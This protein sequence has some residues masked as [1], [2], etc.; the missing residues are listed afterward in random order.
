[1]APS[2]G[3]A[4]ARSKASR[5]AC[6]PMPRL[7]LRRLWYLDGRKMALWSKP[8]PSVTDLAYIVRLLGTPLLP[9]GADPVTGIPIVK[10][11]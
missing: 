1:M 5:V 3:E 4:Q 7:E 6:R 10:P 11:P 8:L 9:A 2:S